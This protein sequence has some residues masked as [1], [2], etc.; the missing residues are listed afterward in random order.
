MPLQKWRQVYDDPKN[1]VQECPQKQEAG[2]PFQ[3][4]AFIDRYFKGEAHIILHFRCGESPQFAACLHGKDLGSGAGKH[5]LLEIMRRGSNGRAGQS[6]G[7][8]I[9][10][11][12]DRHCGNR[13]EQPMLVNN[14][15]SMEL[16]QVMPRSVLVRLDTIDG[17]I[18]ELPKAWYF[19]SRQAFVVLGSIENWERSV[20]AISGGID[21]ADERASEMIKRASEIVKSIPE[22][23]TQMCWDFRDFRRIV[24]NLSRLVIHFSRNGVGVLAP[25]NIDSDFELI[26]VFLGP[27]VFY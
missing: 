16:P 9:A 8:W 20:A 18:R 13:Q 4:A 2:H 23:E 27:L 1:L 7:A 25:E 24:D 19:A 26:D 10:A 21:G 5:Q 14:V 6:F 3:D 12:S 22:H 17:L 15:E 11:T